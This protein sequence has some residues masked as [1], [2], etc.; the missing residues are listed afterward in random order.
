MVM[1]FGNTMLGGYAVSLTM[2]DLYSCWTEH[3]AYWTKDSKA[4]LA[5]IREIRNALP[6]DIK[7]VQA[8]SGSEFINSKVFDYMKNLKSGKVRFTRSGPYKKNDSGHVEQKNHTHVRRL[9]GYARYD[10][11]KLLS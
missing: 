7:S 5:S 11:L 10:G 3:R 4:I 1:Y 8:D 2:T 9:L 6:F